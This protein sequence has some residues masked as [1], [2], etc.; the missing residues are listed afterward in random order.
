MSDTDSVL[1]LDSKTVA[2][3]EN[4]KTVL[5]IL[6]R[7]IEKGCIVKIR[8]E[9]LFDPSTRQQLLSYPHIYG[10]V[11][12]LEEVCPHSGLHAWEVRWFFIHACI[13]PSDH[14]YSYLSAQIETDML[15][16]NWPEGEDVAVGEDYHLKWYFTRVDDSWQMKNLE[17][18]CEFCGAQGCDR[19]TLKDDLDKA[20]DEVHDGDYLENN[21]RRYMMYGLY[22]RIRYGRL[23][24]GNRR[25]IQVCCAKLI[26]LHFPS[27]DGYTGFQSA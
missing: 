12:N 10:I 13:L 27:F 22:I 8:R 18:V 24:V 3:I 19:M 9:V 16:V 6:P 17:N 4:F 21:G 7:R 26:R 2:D 20:L 14:D 25:T 1:T 15:I 23:R 11:T 5:D